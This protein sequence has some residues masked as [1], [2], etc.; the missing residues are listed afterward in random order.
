LRARAYIRDLALRSQF[1]FILIAI[2]HLLQESSVFAI[3]VYGRIRA[4]RKF[5]YEWNLQLN[6]GCGS[7]VKP[8]WLNLDLSPWADYRLDLRRE[9]PLPDLSC[10]IIYSEHF[11]EHLEYPTIA[12]SFLKD[13]HRLLQPGGVIQLS[14]PD[15]EPPL[16]A[17]STE[18][19]VAYFRSVTVRAWHDDWCHTPLEHI[20]Y[21]FRQSASNRPPHSPEYH[22]FAY[23][24]ETM[25]KALSA[26]GFVE[27]SRRA[28]DEQMDS[29]ERREG[30]LL[31]IAKKPSTGQDR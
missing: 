7:K 4:R 13:C 24:Y 27:I 23:D 9:L 2:H 18:N 21:H 30:S 3:D 22:H 25:H 15:S 26:A 20:N 10:A 19:S 16:R 8:G 28:F 17:Y 29:P 31:I 12:S 1:R 14:V 11:L 6:L 5:A